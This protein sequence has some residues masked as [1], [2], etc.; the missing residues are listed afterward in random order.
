MKQFKTNKLK[1]ATWRKQ[2]PRR[3]KKLSKENKIY[4]SEIEENVTHMKTEQNALFKKKKHQL[5]IDEKRKFK[6]ITEMKT[7]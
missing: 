3:E 1:K 7:Q 2:R 6:T 5:F 4:F